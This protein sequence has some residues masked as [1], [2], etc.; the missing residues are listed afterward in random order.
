M[1]ASI[2]E[3]LV[4]DIDP[5]EIILETD[6]PNLY[7]LPAH[8]DLVGAEIEM[9][10]MPKREYMMQ[11]VIEK[12]KDDYDFILIDCSP[13][14]GLIT[15]NALTASDSVIIPVQCEYFALEGLGKLLNTIKIVQNRLNPELD[16][17]GILL[18]MYDTR[19]RLA[20]QVVEEVKMHFQ[21]LVFDTIIHRNTK[22][23]EAPS[24]GQTI[25]MHDA[26][27]KGA[28]N[29]LNLAREI[30]EKN[31]LVKSNHPK[32]TVNS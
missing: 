13:S 24:F 3:C 4:D 20:N 19:L 31:E 17:E 10:N 1:D 25:I 6:N 22:L 15:L 11:A 32:S 26:T 27:G 29:Y 21:Q 30:L 7:I 5:R 16:I 8:I 23:G 2:Y 28:I 9:I 12:F 14:L 18:T